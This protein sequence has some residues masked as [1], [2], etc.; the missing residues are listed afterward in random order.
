MTKDEENRL[1]EIYLRAYVCKERATDALTR[2]R[3]I[4]YQIGGKTLNHVVAT[5]RYNA[6]MDVMRA[7][8]DDA[9]IDAIEKEARKKYQAD[10][11]LFVED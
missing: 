5:A 9:T 6:V 8:F 10:P 1:K 2:A 11:F 4:G 3:V 7:F